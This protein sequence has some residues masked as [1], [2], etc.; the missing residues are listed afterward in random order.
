MLEYIDNANQ[1]KKTCQNFTLNLSQPEADV[2]FATMM[3]PPPN[4]AARYFP[5]VTDLN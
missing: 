4:S 1:P 2:L 5:V 3:L